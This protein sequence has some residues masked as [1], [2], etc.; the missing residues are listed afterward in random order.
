MDKRKEE[1]ARKRQ[2]LA[3]LRRLKEERNKVAPEKDP[4]L[5]AEAPRSRT[6]DVRDLVNLLLNDKKDEKRPSTPGPTDL[7]GDSDG[8]GSDKEPR[9][10]PLNLE[11]NGTETSGS[12]TISLPQSPQVSASGSRFIPD[13]S[14]FEAVILD[15]APKEVV[16]YDKEAQTKETSTNPP[17]PSEDEIRERVEK[18]LAQREK[19]RL[20]QIEEQKAKAEAERRKAAKARDLN[21]EQRKKILA[22]VDFVEFVDHSTRL[23]GRVLSDDYD[24]MKD[25][26]I[27]QVDD[28]DEDSGNRV[29]YLYSF[30]DER[31]AKSRATR[32]V[33]DVNWSHKFPE[34]C[35]ASYNKNPVTSSEP[36]GLVL[37]WN[38]HLLARPEYVFHAQSDVLTTTFSPFHPNYIIGGCYS[39][40]IVIWDNRTKSQPV[41]KTPLSANGHTHPIYSMQMVGSQNAHNLITASTDGLVC[42]WQ[43]DMLTQ[44]QE[45]LELVHPGHSKTDEVSVTA[46][47]FP[48]AE[49][50]AFWVGTEEGN[51]YQ[52]NRF[53][54]AGSKAGINQ[55]DYYKGHWGPVTGLEFHPLV[56][57]VNFSD[58][59]LTSSVDWTVK[60]WR[61][62]S[63][64]RPSSQVQTITPLYSFEGADD[65]VYDVKWSPNHPALF[66][67]VDG[68]GRFSLWNLNMDT[69]VPVVGLNVGSGKAL[70]KIQWDKE[71]RK[72]AIGSSDA[73]VHVYDIGELGQAH[74]DESKNLQKVIADMAAVSEIESARNVAVGK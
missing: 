19:Q 4:A 69:E 61:A 42:A 20:A 34:L 9:R 62:K 16:F 35:V 6:E 2:K 57:K 31:W 65:Y 64:S 66:A 38:M 25:Y 29:K 39:G 63:A 37:V 24:F 40:Q 55:Y 33:T 14:S 22:S 18:E 60:L 26:S 12:P 71:G 1:L 36:D 17:A 53:D 15:I 74:P 7:V 30:F 52:A 67:S 58:L 32:S 54:R 23:V 49:T 46:L 50:T 45:S 73:K 13:F 59:F 27:T 68:T 11:S 44:P 56:G 48:D 43:L 41:L 51:V 8:G 72:V 70:N 10:L 28:T 47:G 5:A 3:E 21:E